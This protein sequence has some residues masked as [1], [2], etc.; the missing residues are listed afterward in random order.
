MAKG[1]KVSRTPKYFYIGKTRIVPT[2]P[3]FLVASEM[4]REE[5]LSLARI[6]SKRVLSPSLL[7]FCTGI[8]RQRLYKWEKSV[9]DNVVMFDMNHHR[10]SFL[11]AQGKVALVEACKPNGSGYCV[12]EEEFN[13][14]VDKLI[15]DVNVKRNNAP[16]ESPT[17]TTRY[18]SDI[19]K[20]LNIKKGNAECTTSA[21]MSAEADLRNFVSYCSMLQ[22]FSDVKPQLLFNADATQFTVGKATMGSKCLYYGRR[23]EIGHLRLQPVKD[24][25]GGM[26]LFIKSFLLISAAGFS[27][28]AVYI[29]ADANMESNSIDVYE[30]YHLSHH[31]NVESK[32]FVVFCKTRQL[33]K[34]FFTWYI[35]DYF[36]PTVA[37]VRNIYGYSRENRAL[38]TLD[39]EDIQL[40]PYKNPEIQKMLSDSN[41]E[42]AK[43]PASTTA[44]TQPCD[45]GNCF[46]AAKTSLK[47]INDCQI[48]HLTESIDAVTNL[49]QKHCQL[50]QKLEKDVVRSIVY[51]LM[52]IKYACSSAYK[53]S[54]IE[55]SFAKS[56]AYPF[57]IV[58]VLRNCSTPASDIE[59]QHIM[60]ALP[61]LTKLYK[62]QGQLCEA[63]FEE[64]NIRKS[65]QN[66]T[67][68]KD[69]LTISRRRTVTLTNPEISEQLI[70]NA[71]MQ[72][73]KKQAKL[74]RMKKINS[75][76]VNENTSLIPRTIIMENKHSEEDKE[77]S[78]YLPKPKKCKKYCYCRCDK[79]EDMIAC[80]GKK[81]PFG[82]WLHIT[83][84]E[85]LDVN[86]IDTFYCVVCR[87]K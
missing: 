52:R 67:I 56:G 72:N 69:K 24:N 83:C 84:S 36:I 54:T 76:E 58:K 23:S 45:V 20:E 64:F 55:H 12:A 33:C 22:S 32:G 70:S 46:K 13:V 14:L 31:S 10:P 18:C 81:C 79:P 50:V 29:V 80:E 74:D 38:L 63:D 40:A 73:Q 44:A 9:K 82:G 19:R 57:D 86:L 59:V 27:G 48:S 43:S 37:K 28:N 6:M 65:P 16:H 4:R 71:N 1:A 47:R 60:K 39:G 7:S 5:K 2:K 30:S 11:D 25:A 78:E 42:V 53:P 8:P 41:I 85:V 61:D 87:H 21:R 75:I 49:V 26:N 62:K 51:G 34:E 66:S 17:A 68:S 3:G 35:K 15:K 77:I